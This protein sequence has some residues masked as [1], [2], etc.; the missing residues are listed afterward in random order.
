MWLTRGVLVRR[1]GRADQFYLPDVSG[2]DE[3]DDDD[4]DLDWAE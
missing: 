4:T 1:Q 3:T 2:A